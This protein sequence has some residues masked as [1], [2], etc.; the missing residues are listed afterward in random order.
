M[1]GVNE[2][3]MKEPAGRASIGTMLRYY[4]RIMS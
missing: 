1:A 3:V 2:A 4:T